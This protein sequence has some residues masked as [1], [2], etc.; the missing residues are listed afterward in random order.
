MT[1]QI[2]KE[3]EFKSPKGLQV[4]ATYTLSLTEIKYCDGDS[5]E[6]GCCKLG[7][8]IKV[9]GLGSIGGYIDRTIRAINGATYPAS[10]G[11]LLLTDDQLAAI[12]SIKVDLASHPKYQAKIAK[13]EKNEREYNEEMRRREANGYCARCGSYCYGD[14]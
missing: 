13:K 7:L 8:D 14:C 10:C 4:V 9:D 1:N 5:I 3:Y 12:D 2:N 6:V 11:Q